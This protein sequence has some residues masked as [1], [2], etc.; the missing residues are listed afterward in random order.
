[1]TSRKVRFIVRLKERKNIQAF[2]KTQPIPLIKSSTNTTCWHH[3]WTHTEIS[4]KSKW[5]FPTMPVRLSL[6]H[7][8]REK[9]VCVLNAPN[10]SSCTVFLFLRQQ[11]VGKIS[12]CTISN[13]FL[14]CFCLFLYDWGSV[15]HLSHLAVLMSCC[16]TD[17]K[18]S[19]DSNL[20]PFPGRTISMFCQI[21]WHIN[22]KAFGVCVVMNMFPNDSNSNPWQY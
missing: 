16:Y 17:L 12:Q 14:S 10:W 8:Q 3:Q 11:A 20:F 7:Q 9:D 22:R 6:E 5:K 1:M 21:H 19:C 15:C 13:P 2:V 18:Q 4:L